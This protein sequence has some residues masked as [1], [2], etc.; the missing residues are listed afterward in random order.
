MS[1]LLTYGTLV[2]ELSLAIFVW[3]RVLRP[4]VLTLG[5][6]LHVA[7]DFSL[8]IGFFSMTILAAYLA[9]V[10]PETAS[11]RIQALRD[12]W[13]RKPPADEEI[14]LPAAPLDGVKNGHPQPAAVRGL[15]AR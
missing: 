4:W 13:T 5:V 12:R 7:I 8:V 14:E 2:L 3:H 15:V 6:T 1:E 11:R 9:F 10:P